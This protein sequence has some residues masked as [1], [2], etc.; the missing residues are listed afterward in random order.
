[1][2]ATKVFSTEHV[3][4]KM[5]ST[6]TTVL[7]GMYYE[8]IAKDLK[9]FRGPAVWEGTNTQNKSAM[10]SSA[11]SPAAIAP[12]G[13]W[14]QHY[15]GNEIAN[16]ACFTSIFAVAKEHILQKPLAHYISLL[17]CVSHHSNPEEGHYLERSWQAVFGTIPEECL[18]YPQRVIAPVVRPTD[19]LS[20]GTSGK[21]GMA[22]LAKYKKVA[23][24]K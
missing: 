22:L 16:V 8:N 3:M 24:N 2:D 23:N 20:A 14:Y 21:G 10:P 9:T 11:C 5:M 13:N 7:K 4:T 6:K 15:F 17:E 19:S 12:F 18:Y 1:M